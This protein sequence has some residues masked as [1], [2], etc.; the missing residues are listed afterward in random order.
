MRIVEIL[1][2]ENEDEDLEDFEQFKEYNFID[3]N[4]FPMCISLT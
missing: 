2:E 1:C 4:S 3:L